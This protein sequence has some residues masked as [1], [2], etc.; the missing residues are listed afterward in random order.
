MMKEKRPKTLFS[1]AFDRAEGS[2]SVSRSSLARG[3]RATVCILVA[4]AVVLSVGGCEKPTDTHTL[5]DDLTVQAATN[6]T[7]YSTLSSR[8]SENRTFVPN[9]SAKA[10]VLLEEG[11]GEILFG[12]NADEELPMASTTKIMTA[13]V[14]LNLCDDLSQ[15]VPIPSEAVG[16]EGSS[17][18]LKQG[19]IWTVEELLYAL[20][21]HSANDAATALAVSVAGSAENFVK[22]MNETAISLG[23]SHT[24]FEN[25]HGLDS[26]RHYTTAY[27]LGLIMRA[28]LQNSR[29]RQI[30][31]AKRFTVSATANRT[32]RIL[33]NHN[34]ML[35]NYEGVI[36]G[37]TGYT[38]HSGRSLVCAATRNDLTLIAVTI[39][40]PDDWRDHAALFDY[41]YAVWETAV[42][43]EEYGFRYEIPVV[44]GSCKSVTVS[45][46]RSVSCQLPKSRP[47]IVQRAEL[48]RFLYA[49]PKT[50]EHLGTLRF[51]FRGKEIGN[52]PLVVV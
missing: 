7:I 9:L 46:R 15:S 2:I 47:E 20:L 42:L 48:P 33:V 24:H 41:G 38:R 18:Y 12:L 34:K 52:S 19:E 23:L 35:W 31:G 3:A 25:P 45:N 43:A 44:T 40:D 21:L 51:F 10:A 50:G 14:V 29:F 28:A 36:G 32:E 13:L 1:K 37:K 39:N 49:E 27:E 6:T 26:Q 22:S 4:F 5:K 30:S 17:V 11:S 8:I 16:V